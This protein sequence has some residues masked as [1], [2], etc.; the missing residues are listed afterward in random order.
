MKSVYSFAGAL[1]AL[2]LTPLT[3]ANDQRQTVD[4]PYQVGVTYFNAVDYSQVETFTERNDDYRDVMIKIW[5]PAELN[6]AS[7]PSHLGYHTEQYPFPAA[8][9]PGADDEYYNRLKTLL[10]GAFRKAPMVESDQKFPVIFYSPGYFSHLEDSESV[11][12]DLASQGYVVASVGHAHQL[13]FITLSDGYAEFDWNKRWNDWQLSDLTTMT[14][15]EWNVE[16]S[17]YAGRPLSQEEKDRLYHLFTLAEGDRNSLQVWVQDMEFALNQLHKVNYGQVSH[18]SNQQVELSSLKGK[19]DLDNFGAFGLSFGGPTA[20]TFCNRQA[21]CKAAANLDAMH[22]DLSPGNPA[23]KP[24][25]I[26]YQDYPMP[27]NYQLV[28]DQQD[29]DTYMVKVANSRH[30]DFSD[31]TLTMPEVRNTDNFGTIDPYRMNAINRATVGQ[32]FQTYVKGEGSYSSLLEMLE[33]TPEFSRIDSKK[34]SY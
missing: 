15:D 3:Y 14:L 23:R 10:S 20:A 1:C 31:L 22:Y 12:V 5:Y 11:M 34:G 24:L 19:L 28:F 25:M 27:A 18:F 8:V 4:A 33:Q 21:K 26:M 13:Q 7:V 2:I 29:R 16:V 32:F 9:L 30:L 6:E 17:S